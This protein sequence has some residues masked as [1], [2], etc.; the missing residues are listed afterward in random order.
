[1]E[2]ILAAMACLRPSETGFMRTASSTQFKH[3]TPL[4]I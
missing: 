2:V 3:L 4:L 1:M